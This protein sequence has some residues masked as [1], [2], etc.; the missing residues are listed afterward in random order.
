MARFLHC[1]GLL[2]GRIPILVVRNKRRK[3]SPATA[4]NRSETE[5]RFGFLFFWLNPT[6]LRTIV[7]R[8]RRECCHPHIAEEEE[9]Q[10]R[11]RRSSVFLV[12]EWEKER[13]PVSIC[14]SGRPSPF[15]TFV[16]G[17]GGFGAFHHRRHYSI[18]A[19]ACP[20]PKI[21]RV[22][23]AVVGPSPKRKKW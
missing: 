20:S 21:K 14:R 2:L 1:L 23:A 8:R 19:V 15:S 6:S 13:H 22:F 12:A 4:A 5:V 16:A 11:R 10:K 3:P 18:T 17:E 7:R 9:H